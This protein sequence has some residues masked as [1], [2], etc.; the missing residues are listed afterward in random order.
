MLTLFVIFIQ[1]YHKYIN[2]CFQLN[3]PKYTHRD[4]N[5]SEIIL[6]D[7]LKV[8]VVGAEMLKIGSDILQQPDVF[9]S[10]E[11]LLN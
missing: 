8:A 3:N 6:Q 5:S 7:G 11:P 1:N 2:H 9:G 10:K 4:A